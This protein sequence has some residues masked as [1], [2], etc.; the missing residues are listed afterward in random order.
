MTREENSMHSRSWL[1]M[2]GECTHLRS[3]LFTP[4]K[5]LPC[6]NWMNHSD[7]GRKGGEGEK[8]R[9]SGDY[10]MPTE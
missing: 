2:Q 4:G 7:Y 1:L 6:V 5:R 10:K 9:C 8:T 3:G